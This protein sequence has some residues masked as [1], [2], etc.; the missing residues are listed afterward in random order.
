MFGL[1][2]VEVVIVL[3]VAVLSGSENGRFDNR[4]PGNPVWRRRYLALSRTR[5]LD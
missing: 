4:F 2:P 3:I 1:G 5:H